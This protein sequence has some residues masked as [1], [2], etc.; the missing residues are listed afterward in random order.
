MVPSRQ[1]TPRS[2]TVKILIATSEAVPFATADGEGDN[3]HILATLEPG[4][5]VMFK[6]RRQRGVYW[7]DEIYPA[8]RPEPESESESAEPTT[9]PAEK[10]P[11]SGSGTK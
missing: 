3:A 2:A 10:T 8:S 11:T 4:D 9:Q 1:V 5:Y 6:Y 7:L